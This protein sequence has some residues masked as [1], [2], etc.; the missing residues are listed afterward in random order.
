VLSRPRRATLSVAGSVTV[1]P[2]RT[3]TADELAE[4]LIAPTIR[5]IRRIPAVGRVALIYAGSRVISVGFFLAVYAIAP[6]LHLRYASHLATRPSFFSLLSAWDGKYYEQIAVHSY[7]TQ[8][9]VDA[10]GHVVSNAWAFLP[11][12]PWLTRGVMLTTGLDFS[13]S[14]VIVS[15]IAGALAAILL[16]RLLVDRI[17]EHRALWSVT[18]FCAGP[19]AFVFELTYAESLSLALLFAALL[20]ITQ[21]HYLLSIPFGV[22]AAFTRPGELALAATIAILFIIALVRRE[23][24][25]P[26]ERI[27][28]IIAGVSLAL[29]GFAWPLIANA[30]TGHKSAYFDTELSWW[31]GWV[32]RVH[33]FPFAP[34]F[35]LFDR[36]LGI[37]GFLI[38]VSI[39]AAFVVWLT[40]R[41]MRA[42][43]DGILA[44]VASYGAYLFAVFL[45]QQSIA[46][47]I[48]PMSPLLGTPAFTQ[49][50]RARRIIL[51]A[52]II[53][54]PFAIIVLWMLYPP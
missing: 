50:P 32:G 29:A 37:A 22:A 47:L 2:A 7:P 52:L 43:G 17:G 39:I 1:A 31:T 36:Y 41:Q 48:M 21:R 45:P 4:Q 46:R 38:V 18:F 25:A 49:S 10:A 3:P 13:A 14:G 24:V 5:G 23:T 11:I 33:F 12:Y 42:L 44:F 8:L 15:L 35:D 53:S 40:R 20:A 26:G 9:P 27:R 19:M 6:V 51:A 54:Q 28:M 34:W 30:V 16:Y